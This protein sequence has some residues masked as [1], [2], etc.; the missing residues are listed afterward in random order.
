MCT[1]KIY[2]AGIRSIAYAL[3]SEEL[4]TMTGGNFLIPCAGLFARAA[5]TVHITGP[6]LMDEA[7]EV[8]LGYWP[9]LQA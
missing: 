8:H 3:S 9:A 1:G 6:L 5:D 4:A 7:R 2:W